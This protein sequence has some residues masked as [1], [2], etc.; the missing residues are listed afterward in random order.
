[1]NLE[2]MPLTK[3]VYMRNIG[4]Y[5]AKNVQLM[6]DFKQWVKKKDLFAENLVI[7]GIIHDNVKMTKPEECRYDVA[8]IVDES[9]CKNIDKCVKKGI[10]KGWNY[11]VFKIEH[12]SKA[13]QA[14][15]STC[16]DVLAETGYVFDET[17]PV[18]ERYGTT[19]IKN[20]FCEICI[21][22]L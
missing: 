19:L 7:L 10:L 1:M 17:R 13:I 2:N 21:P 11:A 6:I 3:I 16:F 18:L 14:A 9:N 8:L 4:P 15:W 12:T 5:G 20:H 22:V